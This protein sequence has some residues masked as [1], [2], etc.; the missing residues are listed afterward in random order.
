M[1]VLVEHIHTQPEPPSQYAEGIPPELDRL[2][3][4]CLEKDREKRVGSTDEL[5]ERLAS[6]HI[7][8]LWT[9]ARARQWWEIYTRESVEEHN[10]E[11]EGNT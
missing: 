2:V 8:S 11:H 9:A 7:S 4:D 5:E 10:R 1:K 3:L 6:I